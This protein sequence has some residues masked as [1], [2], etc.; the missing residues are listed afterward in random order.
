MSE[1]AGPSRR[2]APLFRPHPWHGVALGAAAPRRVT[3]YV[4]IVPTDTVKYE[5][6]KESGLLHID[7]PQKYS[8]LCPTLYGFLPR[9]YC[10]RRVGAF[11]AARSGRAQLAGDG[12]PLDICVLTE[13]TIPRGDILL[14][15]IPIG[16]LRLV[17]GDE[18]DD[19]LIAV[20]DGDA[21]YGGLADIADGPRGLLDRLQHY[22]LT[23]KQA[24]GESPRTALDG[25]Y[26]REEAWEVIRRSVDDYAERFPEIAGLGDEGER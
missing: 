21:I 22:F 1:S 12:D 6:D 14:T 18:A 7:R 11:S 24:P 20:L 3:V 25:T 4:E 23:Y 17:D 8:N 13:K 26:G 2:R 19:K 5:I 15:A 16:G 10:G 9:T